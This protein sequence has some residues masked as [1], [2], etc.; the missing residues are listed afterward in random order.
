VINVT[1][2]VTMRLLMVAVML[3]AVACTD[4]TAIGPVPEFIR[5]TRISSLDG[6]DGPGDTSPVSPDSCPVIPPVP[7]SWSRRPLGDEPATV[8]LPPSMLGASA[9][10]GGSPGIVFND[11]AVGA[12]AIGYGD[13]QPVLAGS[14]SAVSRLP[15]LTFNRSCTARVNDR[16]V[17]ILFSFTIAETSPGVRRV[18]IDPLMIVRISSPAGRRLNALITLHENA[19]RGS[20]TAEDYAARVLTLASIVTSAQW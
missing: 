7:A 9:R 18:L 13:E 17:S 16:A 8:A 6:I 19:A 20:T 2:R 10:F 1:L 5:L 3:T 4:P 14:A 15:F 12:V 11:P